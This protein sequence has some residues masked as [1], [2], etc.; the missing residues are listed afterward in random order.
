MTT[1]SARP[2]TAFS[3]ITAGFP[4]TVFTPYE[5]VMA[6]TDGG[7]SYD[8][9]H[10]GTVPAGLQIML[11][12]APLANYPM[13]IT[14][15]GNARTI[16]AAGT[17]SSGQVLVDFVSGLIQ[18][19]AADASAS[20][21]I[22]YR[23][24]GTA[25]DATWWNTLQKELAATQS[26][27]QPYIYG[28]RLIGEATGVNLKTAATTNVGA[29]LTASVVLTRLLVI[30]TTVSSITA[31]PEC[32]AG[33]NA[34]G[35]GSYLMSST[36]LTGLSTTRP[37]QWVPSAGITVICASGNRPTFTVGTGATGTTLTATI[38]VYG[39]NA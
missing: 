1:T 8:R 3:S 14:V 38:R 35:A 11:D 7:S 32:T 4:T 6:T 5:A 23:G 17:P 33:T 22:T 13:V 36:I 12:L 28:E 24:R 29:V 18:F 20:Y 31:M 39:I 25:L 15:G 30:P 10:T 2:V 34:S 21:S 9:T 37:F 26:A 16:I 19:A 27:V